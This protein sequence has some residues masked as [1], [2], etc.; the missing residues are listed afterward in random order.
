M[1]INTLEQSRRVYRLITRLVAGSV[2]RSPGRRAQM[3]DTAGRLSST[4]TQYAR[5]LPVPEW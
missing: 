1:T 2:H 3:L 5:T 4:L